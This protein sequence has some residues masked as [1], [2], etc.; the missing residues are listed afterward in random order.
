M[1]IWRSATNAGDDLL[2]LQSIEPLDAAEA[3][4]LAQCATLQCQICNSKVFAADSHSDPASRAVPASSSSCHIDLPDEE[5][6]A[7][8][9]SMCFLQVHRNCSASLFDKS[10]PVLRRGLAAFQLPSILKSDA[11]SNKNLVLSA[12]LRV[13]NW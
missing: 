2:E 10:D 5:R 12:A 1:Q 13:G 4:E 3:A 11:V 7:M 8:T 9:C 6:S